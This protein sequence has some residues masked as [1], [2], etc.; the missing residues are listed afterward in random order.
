MSRYIGT[1]KG[2]ETLLKRYKDFGVTDK[3][4]DITNGYEAKWLSTIQGCIDSLGTDE[5]FGMDEID[6]ENTP[7]ELRKLWVGLK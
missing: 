6:Y 1:K 4:K 5:P 3:T 7:K 2:L